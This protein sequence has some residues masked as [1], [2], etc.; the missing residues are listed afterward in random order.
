MK[1]K[2]L[3]FVIKLFV[4]FVA[5]ALGPMARAA[6]ID[7]QLTEVDDNTL[8][9]GGNDA[10][11]WTVTGSGDH[12]TATRSSPLTGMVTGSQTAYWIEPDNSSE[13]NSFQ[14]SYAIGALLTFS[15]FSDAEGSTDR[16]EVIDGTVVSL[17]FSDANGA[18]I[19]YTVQFIDDGDTPSVPDHGSTA[20]CL[21]LG[22]IP[23][24]WLKNRRALCHQ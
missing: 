18:P 24:V 17:T 14:M 6:F 8:T 9:V 16:K 15:V 11:N 20:L 13:V 1:T 2:S 10:A 12:W 19:P 23:L 7:L 3:N 21:M 4:L 22:L 5:L